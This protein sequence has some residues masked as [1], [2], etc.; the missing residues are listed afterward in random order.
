MKTSKQREGYLNRH[1][2]P[3]PNENAIIEIVH[4]DVDGE[5]IYICEW[6]PFDI[7]KYKGLMKPDKGYLGTAKVIIGEYK[8]IGF[9]VWE[10]NDSEFV[11]Y[12]K[13]VKSDTVK[14][15]V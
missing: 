11:Y 9:N 7:N 8:G 5:H 15:N 12:N 3:L 14:Q 13:F 1:T 4:N 6:E 10:Q 2:D